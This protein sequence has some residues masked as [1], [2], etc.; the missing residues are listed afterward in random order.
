LYSNKTLFN[1]TLRGN[2]KQVKKEY[3]KYRNSNEIYN[4]YVKLKAWFSSAYINY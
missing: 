4:E 3:K 1:K 2:K